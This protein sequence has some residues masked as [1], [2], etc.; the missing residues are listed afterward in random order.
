M[1]A[2]APLPADARLESLKANFDRAGETV[3]G[4]FVA[5]YLIC[6]V[7]VSLRFAGRALHEAL[8]PAFAHLAA[9]ASEPR[10]PR[11]TVNLWDSAS[12]GSDPPPRPLDTP[13]HARGAMYHFRE[14]PLR[15]VFQAELGALSV[16]DERRGEAWYWVA[17]ARDIP[18]WDRA[19]PIRQILFWWL[20]SQGYLMVHGA[21][22]GTAAGGALV[23]GP[24]GVGKSTVALA[25]LHSDLLYAGDDYVAVT[26]DPPRVASLYNSGKLERPHLHQ[27]L[28]H[29]ATPLSGDEPTVEPGEKEIVYVHERLPGRTAAGF[30]LVAMLVPA[31][32]PEQKKTRVGPLSRPAAFAA[33]APS[34]M[35]QLHTA[36]AE[37][38]A[39]LSRLVTLVP[40]YSLEVGSQLSTIPEAIS[41]LLSA[42]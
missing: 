31:L 22:I 4:V 33:L 8:T 19:S 2:A 7:S 21:A 37:E 11:L 3:G 20:A 32:R 41:E 25:C 5:D 39:T 16:F 30:P 9:A 14:P 35:L 34:T 38:F 23:V 13:G 26:L 24:G 10:A 12:A 29:L 28:P 40:C 6:G 27:R 18:S 36:G 1:A 42:A 17:D 15:G